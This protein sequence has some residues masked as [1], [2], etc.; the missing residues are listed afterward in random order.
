MAFSPL[1]Q[2]TLIICLSL[3]SITSHANEI[4]SVSIESASSLLFYPEKKSTALVKSINHTQV[5]AQ[6]AAQVA[7][8]NVQLGSVVAKGQVL[9][10]LDCQDNTINLRKQD[11]EQAVAKAQYLLAKRNFDRAVQL[12]RNRHIG[13]AE[14]DESE[15]NVTVTHER[16][17]K[18]NAEQSAASLAVKRCQ[19][20][21]PFAGLVT[22]R[23]V[24]EGS[25]VTIGQSLIK[26]L[27][28][29]NIEIE[30]QI[31][32]DQM[33]NLHQA[34]RYYFISS[35]RNN[36]EKTPLVVKNIV[37]FVKP[38]SRSQVVT[39]S[40]QATNLTDSAN[41]KVLA[42]MNGMVSWQSQHSFLP[43]HILTQRNG[44]YGIFVAKAQG[45]TIMAEFIE[46]PNAQEGR[47]F[48][49]SIAK[50]TDIIIDGRHRITANTPVI[51]SN[52]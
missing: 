2:L 5:P 44:R 31:P 11:A 41:Q 22:E 51:V 42:G 4:Q 28:K 23:L 29:N 10:T 20:V 7:N 30:A 1:Y 3:I 48:A 39:F 6:I 50:D 33:N 40:V 24:S 18:V 17:Q 38:N 34:K 49:L 12:K 8:I 16:L 37:D 43:A 26:V 27:E 52:K 21:S 14:L 9:V 13:E 36:V 46:L 25:Y 45:D 15:V 47:P 35:G 32:L 19:V